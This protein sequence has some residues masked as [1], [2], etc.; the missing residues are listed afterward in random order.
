ML[1]TFLYDCGSVINSRPLT[2]VSDYSKYLI[3]FILFMLLT[4]DN[5][6]N[7]S[8]FDEVDSKHLQRRI[9]YRAK[10]FSNHLET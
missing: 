7:V 5:Y 1:E 4:E 8:D 6:S 2:C 10:P 9:K 3:P